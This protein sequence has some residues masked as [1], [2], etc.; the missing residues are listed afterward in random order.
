MRIAGKAILILFSFYIAYDL[1]GSELKD[2]YLRRN[3]VCKSALLT[4]ELTRVRY[5]EAE[6]VY[7]LTVNGKIY[8][9]N[10]ENNKRSAGSTIC[11]I[12]LSNWPSIN[13]PVK[14]YEKDHSLRLA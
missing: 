14:F 2:W 11:I 4:S 12:Y 6:L 1:V 3:G 13:K 7:E 5:H 9:G 10:L 8:K